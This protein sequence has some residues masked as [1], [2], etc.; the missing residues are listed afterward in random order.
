M[1]GAR[2]VCVALLGFAA[3]VAVAQG[4]SGRSP[5]LT[6]GVRCGA[7]LRPPAAG[8][9]RVSNLGLIGLEIGIDYF[10]VPPVQTSPGPLDLILAKDDGRPSTEQPNLEIEIVRLDHGARVPAPA[11]FHSSGVSGGS[12]YRDKLPGARFVRAIS[13]WLAVPLDETAQRTSF[14]EFLNELRR[15]GK[16]DEARRFEG[17]RTNQAMIENLVREHQPGQYELSARFRP[18]P[19]DYWRGALRSGPLR[20]D[21]LA[22][23]RWFDALST[24][25]S[26]AGGECE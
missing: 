18:R 23:G 25:R 20:L 21:I 1:S 2:S 17:F 10:E 15:A 24:G 13:V 16:L 4:P 8:A 7:E 12:Q 6:L 3:Q 19:S 14:Q 26:P 9:I 5:V 11:R 22:K